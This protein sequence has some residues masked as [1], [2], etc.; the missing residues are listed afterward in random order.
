MQ[1][2]PPASVT[3][4]HLARLRDAVTAAIDDPT[5]DN[6]HRAASLAAIVGLLVETDRARLVR[7]IL[8]DDPD[9][10][11]VLAGGSGGE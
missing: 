3:A 10:R 9:V 11:R 2:T 1:H 4:A 8:A 7:S 6:L 5:D